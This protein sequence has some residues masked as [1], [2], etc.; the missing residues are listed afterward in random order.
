[1]SEHLERM[2]SAVILA[3]RCSDDHDRAE[4]VL[5]TALRALVNPPR[6]PDGVDQRT[7][8]MGAPLASVGGWEELRLAVRTV[9]GEIGWDEA[10]RRY[11]GDPRELKDIVYRQREPGVGRQAR[12]LQVVSGNTT[13]H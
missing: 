13:K 11:G 9:A 5:E 10:A 1:M 3:S 8:A 12:L 7:D 4:R 2:L 6:P